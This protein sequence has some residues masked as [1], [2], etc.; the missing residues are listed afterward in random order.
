M[1]FGKFHDCSVEEV[2]VDDEFDFREK[3]HCDEFIDFVVEYILV[4][5]FV[6]HH[7][8][9]GSFDIVVGDDRYSTSVGCI[10][11]TKSCDGG[12]TDTAI[13]IVASTDA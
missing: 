10:I 3:V 9:F 5:V 8:I 2:F 6:H 12:V 11:S 7:L 1:L 4:L 13:A